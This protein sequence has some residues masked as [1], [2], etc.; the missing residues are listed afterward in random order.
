MKSHVGTDERGTVHTLVTTAAN[1]ADISQL[2]QLLH[3]EE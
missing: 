3:G 2:S 1:E